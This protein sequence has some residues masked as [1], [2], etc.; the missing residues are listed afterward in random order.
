M[1]AQ[2][3][4]SGFGPR[5]AQRGFTLIEMLVV[6]TIMGLLA[7][8]A[9]TSFHRPA[10]LDRGKVRAALAAAAADARV[11][12]QASGAPQTLD[13]KA[14]QYAGLTFQAAPGF[15]AASP[16]F[17]PDGSG[18]GG[19]FRMRGNAIATLDW[20]TGQFDHAAP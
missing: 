19:T 11:R 4:L 20:A 18:T 1:T 3:R 5:E 17:Y 14:A 6:L 9:I 12:A 13:L 16:T 10:F 15:A 2:D 8:V 7:A